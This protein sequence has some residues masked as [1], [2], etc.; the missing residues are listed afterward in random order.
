MYYLSVVPRNIDDIMLVV[1]RRKMARPTACR[2]I[3]LFEQDIADG[4]VTKPI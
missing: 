4:A 3:V 2:V 1:R